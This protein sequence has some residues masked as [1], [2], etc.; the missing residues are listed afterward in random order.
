LFAKV[1]KNYENRN[2][3][4]AKMA[5]RCKIG[6]KNKKNVIFLEKMFDISEKCSIFVANFF[7]KAD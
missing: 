4:R 6:R 3:N 7:G 2:K 5:E 1:I